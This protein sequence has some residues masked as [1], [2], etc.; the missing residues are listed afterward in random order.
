MSDESNDMMPPIAANVVGQVAEQ[1]LS[2]YSEAAIADIRAKA[3]NAAFE[4]AA[5]ALEAQAISWRDQN[6]L[7]SCQVAS[8]IRGNATAIRK[9]KGDQ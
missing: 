1:V 8:I 7:K 3:R 5:E 9:L 6:T 4:E 2:L